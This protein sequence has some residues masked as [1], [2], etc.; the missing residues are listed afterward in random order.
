MVINVKLI[1]SIVAMIPFPFLLDGRG[2]QYFMV[3]KFGL[4]VIE[5]NDLE[6][7]E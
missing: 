2:D 3:E 1:L 7:S 4:D 6:D 5:A